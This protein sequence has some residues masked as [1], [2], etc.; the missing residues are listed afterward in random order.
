MRF[1][2]G[3]AEDGHIGFGQ[4]TAAE[5]AAAASAEAEAEAEN[6]AAAAVA[7]A[8]AAVLA[9]AP[10]GAQADAAGGAKTCMR[11]GWQKKQGN[12]KQ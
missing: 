1:A 9:A 4:P 5:V 11:C 8:A 2:K 6:A 12:D 3:P 7:A 10:A